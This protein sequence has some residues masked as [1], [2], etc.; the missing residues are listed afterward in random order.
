MIDGVHAYILNA[1]L[2][3]SLINTPSQHTAENGVHLWYPQEDLTKDICR[4]DDGS[5]SGGGGVVVVVVVFVVVCND[6]SNLISS[7]SS[8]CNKELSR[9]SKDNYKCAACHIHIHVA[10]A[11][12]TGAVSTGPACRPTFE[13]VTTSKGQNLVSEEIDMIM[14]LTHIL[15]SR[16]PSITGCWASTAEH[17]TAKSAAKAY[18]DQP[19]AIIFA[20]PWWCILCIQL[21]DFVISTHFFNTLI[22]S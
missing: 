17:Q 22:M 6:Y 8:R 18:V 16:K 11:Q 10:C 19:Y 21:C 5:S 12:S 15:P 9:L 4:C 2:I 14:L 1:L 13:R 7:I 20:I 3:P